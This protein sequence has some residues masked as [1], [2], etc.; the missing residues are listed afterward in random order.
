MPDHRDSSMCYDDLNSF[1]EELR[2][3]N[4]LITILNELAFGL[5]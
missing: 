1:V 2:S 3:A 4:D 5:R